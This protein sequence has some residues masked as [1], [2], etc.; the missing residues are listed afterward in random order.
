MLRAPPNLCKG[1]PGSSVGKE[2]ALRC[3]RPWFDSWVRKIRWRRGRLPTPVF[4][5]F[6]CGSAG[7]ESACNAGDLGLI[8]GMVRTPGERKGYYPLQDSGLKNSTDCIVQRVAKSQIRLSDFHTHTQPVR[9]NSCLSA[10]KR[11]H[12]APT[13]QESEPMIFLTL[14]D[15]CKVNVFDR[16]DPPTLAHV[17]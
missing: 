17:P 10:P 2:S 14:I 4:L 11:H 16:P 9:R 7:K 3:R 8:P 13:G 15:S 12:P 6:P 1:L 5:G